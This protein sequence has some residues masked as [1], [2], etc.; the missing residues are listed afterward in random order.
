MT[1]MLRLFRWRWWI[2]VLADFVND[3]QLGAE[4]LIIPETNVVPALKHELRIDG[5][6]QDL[7]VCR[8]QVLS[9]VDAD[10]IV[11]DQAAGGGDGKVGRN[12]SGDLFEPQHAIELAIDPNTPARSNESPR[13]AIGERECQL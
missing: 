7:G 8:Q 1:L 5:R 6:Q 4:L 13:P 11:I 12:L 2:V 9:L 10:P 3:L